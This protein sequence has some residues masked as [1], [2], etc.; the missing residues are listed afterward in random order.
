MNI[1]TWFINKNFLKKVIYIYLFFT[2]I[3]MISVTAYNYIYTKQLLLEQAYDDIQQNAGTVE[4]SLSSLFRPFETITAELRADKKLN[5]YLSLDYTNLTYSDIA[6][7]TRTS[8][9][10]IMVLYPEIKWIHCYSN[11]DTL[12]NDNYYF[13][14][15]GQIHESARN[16]ADDKRG[17]PIASGCFMDDGEGE[18]VYIANMNYFASKT[19]QN[20][21]ALGIR[22]QAVRLLLHQEREGSEAYLLDKDGIVLASSADH[23]AGSNFSVIIDGWSELACDKIITAADAD[24]VELLCLK[25]DIGANMTLLVTT[26]QDMLLEKVKRTPMITTTVFVLITIISLLVVWAI[27][28]SISKR[29]DKIVY[30]TEKIG[31]GK[32][33]YVLDDMG[34]DE[35][36]RIAGAINTMNHQIDSLIQE[37][38]ERQIKIKVSEMNLLQEQI[39]PHFLY[40]A[41]AVVSSVSLR[42]GGKQTVQ[43]IRYLAD[44][45]RATLSKGRQVIT[46]K[47]EMSLLENYMKIQQLRFADMLNISY[48]IAPEMLSCKMIK[49]ILQPLVENA[50]HHGRREEQTLHI[51]VRGKIM[52]D[53]LCFEVEDDGIGIEPE[54]LEKIRSELKVQ[55]EG[56]GLKNVDIRIKLHYG[57]EYGVSVFSELNK[58]TRIYVEI[59]RYKE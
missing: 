33:D 21:L 47:E 38:Y 8:L 6:Y 46:V 36:G 27:N 10:K 19:V 11:N 57:Q 43:S 35:F 12:P 3:P 48:E 31:E 20:Y 29:L 5:T 26:D 45:Y 37:N 15:L 16:E 41:L 52:D 42:E 53:R 39:N 55:Q 25:K 59:P 24:D 56:F 50:I 58:G 54:Q 4:S 23:L 1:K 2:I 44:F 9:D 14:Q 7:Y 28:R 49:L 30:A 17:Q 34:G 40:N 32:F 13:F 22:Q 51:L 18:I